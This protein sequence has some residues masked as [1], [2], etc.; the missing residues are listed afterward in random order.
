MRKITLLLL[1]TI[2]QTLSYGQKI[3]YTIP[4]GVENDISKDDYKKIVD[5]A[6]PMVQKKY[7]IEFVK[8]GT[9][10]LAKDQGMQAF[11][12]DNLVLKCIEVKDKTLWKDVIQG[13]RS[14][15]PILQN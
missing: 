9:I 7:K 4:S 11:N 5:I 12:L 2:F 15:N 14:A 6:V 3:D 1:V 10:Q 13:I 8:E